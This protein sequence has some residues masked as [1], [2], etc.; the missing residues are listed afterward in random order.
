[1]FDGRFRILD[2][3]TVGERHLKLRVTPLETGT[4][5]V[6]AIL[7]NADA[8]LRADPGEHAELVYRLEVNEFR[9]R[10]NPQLVIEHLF[11]CSTE[12]DA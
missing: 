11:P 8:A 5:T 10:R 3:R 1:V 6:E 9:G 4:P 7:F 2:A 12:A